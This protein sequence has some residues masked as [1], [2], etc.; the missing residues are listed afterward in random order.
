MSEHAST[1]SGA[2]AAPDE[3][4]PATAATCDGRRRH[5][6]LYLHAIAVSLVGGFSVLAWFLA[7]EALNKLLWSNSF[8]T[9][10]RWFFPVICLPLSLLVGLLVKYA[11]A[12]SNLDGSILESLT[13]DV[14]KLEWRKLPVTVATSLA[15][16]FSGAVLGPEGAIGNIASKIAALYCV[17]FHVPEKEPGQAHLRQRGVRVQRPA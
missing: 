1:A 2:A 14:T 13:G 12:P 4:A 9:A 16:L 7:Y 11:H 8:V 15:S 5:A 10:H 6:R 17:V 3:H